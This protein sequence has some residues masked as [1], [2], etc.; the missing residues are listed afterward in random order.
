MDFSRIGLY[1]LCVLLTL[2]MVSPVL[3]DM[4]Q[5]PVTHLQVENLEEILAGVERNFQVNSSEVLGRL[6]I[7]TTKGK[8]R[9]FKVKVYQEGANKL[10]HYLEPADVR[11]LS[12]L[13]L[14]EKIYS[15]SKSTMRV[16]RL[17]D[18]MK[19]QGM[20]GSDL[21]FEDLESNIFGEKYKKRLLPQPEGAKD[22]LVELTPLK[23]SAYGKVIASIDPATSFPD[24]LEYFD[25]DQK[26]LKTVMNGKVKKFADKSVATEIHIKNHK[27]NKE[28]L[29]FVDDIKLDVKFKPRFFSIQNLNRLAR[30]H[31]L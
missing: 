7:T 1:S 19:N 14:D 2:V 9:H 5:Q 10:V 30:S 31:D 3:A 11:G 6:V 20:S 8:K 18:H 21:S 28:T 27:E 4:P 29:Y 24:K 12:F 17:P 25:T 26:P 16:R 22:F 23:D 15:L 13:F